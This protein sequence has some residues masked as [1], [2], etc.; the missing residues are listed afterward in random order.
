[1]ST[2][3]VSVCLRG[4]P[5]EDIYVD[6]DSI[7]VWTFDS[8]LAVFR[9]RDIEE[10][11]KANLMETGYRPEIVESVC[12]RMFHSDE[13]RH[14][15]IQDSTKSPPLLTDIDL[16]LDVDSIGYNMFETR[17]EGDTQLDLLVCRGCVYVGTSDGLFRL[18][19]SEKSGELLTFSRLLKHSCQ[20][21]A[22]SCGIVARLS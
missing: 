22:A 8:D 3:W 2:R 19:P 15:R 12:C 1:M 18:T 21:I 10:A 14:P 16:S 13:S 17:I 4:L 6:G 20:G 9:L 5:T 11:V 7:Y